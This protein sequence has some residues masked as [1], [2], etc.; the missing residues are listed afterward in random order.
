MVGRSTTTCTSDPPVV[1]EEDDHPSRVQEA[2]HGCVGR[3]KLRFEAS[4]ARATLGLGFRKS[5]QRGGN[6]GPNR[7]D[8]VVLQLC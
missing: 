8:F 2:C 6:L 4:P 7:Q 3:Q 5:D 1:I